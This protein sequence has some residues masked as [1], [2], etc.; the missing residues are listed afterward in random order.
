MEKKIQ[1]HNDAVIVAQRLLAYCRANSWSGYDP[2]DAL[3]SRVFSALAL[4][5]S[6]WARLIFSQGVKRCPMNLRSVLLVPRAA[7]P[8]GIA[9]FLASLIKLDEMGLNKDKDDIFY[10]AKNLLE[11]RSPGH[12]YSCWGYNFD[13]Q[14]RTA[15]VPKDYPNIICTTFAGNAMIDLY[16]W[17]KE[18]CWLDIAISAADYLLNEL[19]WQ[20]DNSNSCFSYTS[21]GRSQIHNANLLGAAYLCRIS[22]ISGVK[23]YLSPAIEAAKYSVLRQRSNGSWPYG[24]SPHQQ[25]ID[26]FHTG[27]NL[28]AL[29]LISESARVDAVHEAISKGFE[30]YRKHFF[31][32]D[33]APKYFDNGTYPIDIHSIAQSI[34]TLVHCRDLSTDNLELAHSIFNWAKIHMWDSRGFFYFQKHK[35]YTNRIPFMRWSQAWMLNALSAYLGSL[36]SSD[37]T[38]E[39]IT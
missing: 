19:Y 1:A 38:R 31:R 7:N 32:F 34:I 2:Y 21:K 15:L 17:L 33:G 9:L 12:P 16:Q 3:N 29:K 27:Y 6:K 4:K 35:S 5:K 36:L 25:W 18:S 11:L 22:A 39:S 37:A 23:K 20:G 13:W 26:N 10:L 30:F 8:K 28:V 24:E 14:T